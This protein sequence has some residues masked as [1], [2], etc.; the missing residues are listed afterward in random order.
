MTTATQ[1]NSP[2]KPGIVDAGKQAVFN[3]IRAKWDRFSMQDLSAVKSKDDLVAQVAARYGQDKGQVQ[4][5]VDTILNGRM[6]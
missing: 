6:I 4:R 1:P 2:A 5:E 3:D